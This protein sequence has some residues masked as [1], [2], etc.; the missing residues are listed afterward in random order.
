MKVITRAVLDMESLEWIPSEEKAYH[1]EGPVALA[2]QVPAVQS[3][4]QSSPQQQNRAIRE[5]VLRSAVEMT[6]QI[7]P[8]A[9]AVNGNVWTFNPRNVGLV[10]KFIVIVTG[11]ANNTDGANAANLSDLGLANVVSQV[12]LIDLQNYTRIQTTGAHLKMIER[13]KKRW[14]TQAILAASVAE[15]SEFGN[16]FNVEVAPTGIGHGTSQPFTAVYEVPVAYSDE[17]LTGAMY[18]GVT[19][20]QAQLQFTVN[21]NPFAAAGVDSTSA[22]WKGA[23]GNVSGIN[24]ALYQVFLDQLPRNKAGLPLLPP[25]DTM[26]V[27]DIKNTTVTGFVANNDF[28]IAYANFREFLSTMIIYNHDPSADAGRAGGGD[29]SYFALQVANFANLDKEVPLV[30]ALRTRERW[31]QDPPLGVYMFSSRRRRLSTQTYGNLTRVIN[32]I[33][34]AAGAY[35]LL[36]WEAFASPNQL[37]AGAQSLA[38]S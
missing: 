38:A 31:H 36:G 14:S 29:I 23:A 6:Q 12:Q 30:V 34:A 13:D 1:Y 27:Y 28:P 5:L 24:I 26:K 7:Q 18:L 22:V 25:I 2:A 33:T 15:G 35:A 8:A 19:N 20:T 16:N 37:V 11:E 21:P 9:G 3:S 32:P 10:K 17:D 4:V